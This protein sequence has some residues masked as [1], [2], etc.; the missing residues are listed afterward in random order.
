MKIFFDFD[1]TIVDTS[2]GI[3]NA[4]L[5]AFKKYGYSDFSIN[6]LKSKLIGPPLHNG[7]KQLTGLNDENV[8]RLVF[9]FREYYSSQGVFENNLY[10]DIL[11]VLQYLK[12]RKYYLNIVSS[13]PERFIIKILNQHNIKDF[14]DYIG[15]AG[16]TDKASTKTE[17]IKNLINRDSKKSL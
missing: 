10:K 13:K 11:K 1:G 4:A 15:G 17:K 16:D 14:F 9:F 5:F 2:E 6:D 3:I 7:L 8:E 12:D